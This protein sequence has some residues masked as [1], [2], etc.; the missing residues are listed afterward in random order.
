MNKKFITLSIFSL[1]LSTATFPAFGMQGDPVTV[2]TIYTF[3]PVTPPS[4]SM[5]PDVVL[6]PKYVDP[7]EAKYNALLNSQRMSYGIMAI[8]GITCGY[9]AWNQYKMN[10][11]FQELLTSRGLQDIDQKITQAV[12]VARKVADEALTK[13]EDAGTKVDHLE[14]LVQALPKDLFEKMNERFAHYNTAYKTQWETQQAEWRRFKHAQAE[15]AKTHYND[16][17]ARLKS[18]EGGQRSF[19]APQLKAFA[20]GS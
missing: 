14:K 20:H 1:V 9:L 18:I 12:A 17:D 3:K 6:G 4:P 7:V 5:N 19:L 13:A 11:R 16:F 2:G 15:A 8:L 10:K